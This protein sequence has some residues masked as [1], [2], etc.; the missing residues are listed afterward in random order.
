MAER[1]DNSLL[2]SGEGLGMRECR[3]A[4][5]SDL[6]FLERSNLNY[7]RSRTVTSL[8][9]PN[10]FSSF[11]LF[12]RVLCVLR[13]E[14]LISSNLDDDR[15]VVGGPFQLAHFHMNA[16]RTAARREFWREKNVIDAQSQIALESIH[17][18]VPPGV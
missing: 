17:A 2:P 6:T 8:F 11:L 18:V 16:A 10:C 12:L 15:R 4:V 1:E 14:L 3:K 13:G 5:R 7:Y 9:T